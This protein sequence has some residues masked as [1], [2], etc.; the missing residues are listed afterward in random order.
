MWVV[1]KACARQAGLTCGREKR[2]VQ[3]LKQIL[4]NVGVKD[5]REFLDPP[6]SSHC[7]KGPRLGPLQCFKTRFSHLLL[8]LGDALYLKIKS[9]RCICF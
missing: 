7:E 9:D 4:E 5:G 2:S 3:P 1:H 8:V 6:T